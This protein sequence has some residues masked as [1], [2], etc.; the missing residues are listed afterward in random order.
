M[1]GRRRFSRDE[2]V[3]F[4]I[5]H[6]KKFPLFLARK[7]TRWDQGTWRW[8]LRSE[9]PCWDPSPHLQME[10]KEVSHY[11]STHQW[12]W[13]LWSLPMPRFCHPREKRR[14]NII[15]P[16]TGNHHQGNHWER[17]TNCSF[18]MTSTPELVLIK[19]HGPL[20]RVISALGR[21][22]KTTKAF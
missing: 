3:R 21:W 7:I 8:F 19:G 2:A 16:R 10:A 6:G 15:I 14:I 12:F 17:A 4:R 18:S 11:N 1:N 22:A 20:A 5:C 9:I 13:Y